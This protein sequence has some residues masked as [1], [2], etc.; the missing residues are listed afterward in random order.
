MGIK[1]TIYKLRTKA[2]MSQEQFAALFQVSRQSVQKWESGTS[3][4]ELS[5]IIEISKYFDISLDAMILNRDNRVTEELKYNKEM[6][7]QYSNMHDWEFYTSDILTEYQQSVD[8]GLNI[9]TYKDIFET[10]ARLPKNEIKKKF[11][12]ILFEVVINSKPKDDYKYIEPSDIDGIKALRKEY[13]TADKVDENLLTSKL[14]GAWIGRICGCM[15]GKTVEG[16]RTNELVPFLKET[17]NYPMHRYIYKTD[18]NNKMCTKYSYSLANRPYADEIDGM[19]V[20]DDTNYVVLAQIIIEKY[21]KNFTPY[22][23]SR[24]WLDYQNKDAY[25]TAERVAFCNFV[26]GYEPPES[27]TYKNPYREWIG[28]QIRGD[29]FGYINPGNPGLAA[30]MAWRD[31]SVSHIKNG[32]YGEMFVSAMLAVAA[33]T[34]NIEVIILGGLAQIPYTSR[35]YED[36]MLVLN[37]FKSGVSQGECFKNIHKKYDEY[38]SHGWCHTNPNAMIVAASLLYGGGDYGKSVCMAVETGFDT[39][40]NGAT[41]GSILGM[42]NGIDSIAECWTKPINDTLHTSIFGVG[43]VK[44]SDRVKMTMEHIKLP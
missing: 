7:P 16:M 12:D 19:P 24:A 6:K 4:P 38:T 44:I 14:H 35:L 30:E 2:K 23:V 40:C 34:N 27:A 26:K 1:D 9:E 15:L 43:T 18:I 11:G 8:E 33:V 3:V 29:Y 25:C 41:V 39:D 21:G 17:G 42:A 13:Y 36:I 32:I 28:A 31:A 20:D 22:D 37:G 10:V 5:K